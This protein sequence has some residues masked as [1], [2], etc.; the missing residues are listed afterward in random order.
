VV[1]GDMPRGEMAAFGG[2]VSSGTLA[3]EMPS[4]G[5]PAAAATSDAMATGDMP[6]GRMSDAESAGAVSP[7]I[8]LPGVWRLTLSPVSAT[9]R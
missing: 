6:L 2:A 3:G 5:M 4:G 7:T 8:E 9:I 1:T